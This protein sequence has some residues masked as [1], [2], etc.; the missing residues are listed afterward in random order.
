MNPEHQLKMKPSEQWARQGF[1]AGPL[2]AREIAGRQAV[3]VGSLLFGSDYIHT[4]GTYPSTRRHLSTLLSPIPP[5][6]A[7]AIVAGN[8][9]RMFGFDL[10]KLGQTPAASQSWRTAKQEAA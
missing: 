8:A 3:G 4:E 1:C 7:W 9:A 2:D 10:A 5:K 6:E